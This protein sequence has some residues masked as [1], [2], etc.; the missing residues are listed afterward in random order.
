MNSKRACGDVIDLKRGQARSSPELRLGV[1]AV[2]G[3]CDSL[4]WARLR[5]RIQ[6][7]IEGG[8]PG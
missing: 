2:S 6:L 1:I 4:A 7:G 5:H 3:H 8:P